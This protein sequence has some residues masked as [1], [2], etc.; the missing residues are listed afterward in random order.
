MLLVA[1]P[2]PTVQ[3]HIRDDPKEPCG[4]VCVAAKQFDGLEHAQE[5]IDADVVRVVVTG[6]KA[7]GQVVHAL[8]ISAYEHVEGGAVPRLASL[9]QVPF[10]NFRHITMGSNRLQLP[11]SSQEMRRPRAVG[12]VE[13]RQNALRRA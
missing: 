6:G 8:L 7:V 10:V 9:D 5:R 2:L 13:V 11:R 4:E 3:V 12:G 1:Q